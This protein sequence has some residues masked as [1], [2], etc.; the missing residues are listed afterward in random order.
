MTDTL[1]WQK[2]KDGDQTAYSVIYQNHIDYLLK[3]GFKITQDE[4]TIEDAVHDLFVELWKNRSTVGNTDNI[5]AYL[6]VSLRRKIIKTLQKVQKTNSNRSPEDYDFQVDLAI[7]E[8]ITK[9]EKDK[10]SA[11]RLKKAMDQ[12]GD[13]QKEA[14]YLK[15]YSQ[16]SN[17][18]ISEA[19]NI[20]NQSVRN[21]IYRSLEQLKRIFMWIW[22]II[23][24]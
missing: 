5:R 7:D 11:L 3:Y 12:L 17:E 1:L 22:I 6:T 9:S 10:E 24:F 13:R 15:Y 16:M 23:F 21:L 14:L 20:T 4:A 18:Q 19:M 2:L 8:V